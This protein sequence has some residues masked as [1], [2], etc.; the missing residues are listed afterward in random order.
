MTDFAFPPPQRPSLPIADS[1]A[2]APVR[3]LYCVGRNYAAHTIEMGHDPDREDPFF[4]MKA[5]DTLDTSGQFPYPRRSSDVQ[6]EVELAVLL[7]DG[8]TDI[9]VDDADA[10]VFGYAVALDMTRRDLQSQQKKAGRPW[11]IGKSFDR[12]APIGAIHVTDRPLRAGR[13]SL[14]VDGIERQLGDLN[15]M[16][17][18]TPEIIAFLS[19]YF[20]LAPGD[21]ILTGTPSGVGPV[22]RGQ[23][24][25]AEIEGLA[26][27]DVRVV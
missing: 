22:Q 23:T 11:E 7:R 17:W 19:R 3:R 4:F 9:E 27:L 6:Y 16:I 5:P 10:L 18:K 15:Q 13:I 2:R 1:K 21:L 25:R 12:S 14:S 26:P 20:T 24:M 8:G